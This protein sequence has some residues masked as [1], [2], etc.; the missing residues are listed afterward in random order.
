MIV[1]EAPIRDVGSSQ[2]SWTLTVQPSG[3]FPRG[4]F[5][6]NPGSEFKTRWDEK[7]R[8]ISWYQTHVGGVGFI[9]LE[10]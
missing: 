8:S 10:K 5:H 7:P 9:F 3:M 6:E 4:A 2:A 1:E